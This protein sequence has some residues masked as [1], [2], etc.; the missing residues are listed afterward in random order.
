MSGRPNS[1]PAPSPRFGSARQE[2]E[3]EERRPLLDESR[4]R[5]ER[6]VNGFIDFAFQGN[7]LEIAFGL[8]IASMFTN[9]VTSFVSDI[10]LPPLSVLLPIN[11]NLEE[12][13]A[14][15]RPGPNRPYN[16]LQQAQ[17]DG[18]VVMAYGVFISRLINFI[19]VG[20]SLYGLASMYQWVSH[21]PIIKHTVK[22]Q[23]CR[24]SIS[25]KALRCVNCTSWQDGREDKLH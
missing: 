11:K 22:C 10:L 7:V 25:D 8:I 9:L 16:T 17:D 20:F 15:L 6:I 21:D 2:E 13:F 4:R 1:P 24:K 14:V 3:E 23:Y 12:K 5:V 19:G 18:A